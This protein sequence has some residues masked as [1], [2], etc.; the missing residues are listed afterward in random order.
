[1]KPRT[2]KGVKV[3]AKYL[4]DYTALAY[5]TKEKNI[6]S[7]SAYG[8]GNGNRVSQG[9]Y[10]MG[11]NDMCSLAASPNVRIKTKRGFVPINELKPE[12]E[13]AFEIPKTEKNFDNM[14]DE[15]YWEQG[16]KF[17]QEKRNAPKE[18]LSNNQEALT[19]FINGFISSA[20][21]MRKQEEWYDV[22]TFEDALFLHLAATK[23]RGIIAPIDD[24]GYKVIIPNKSCKQEEIWS[25]IDFIDNIWTGKMPLYALE[26]EGKTQTLFVNGYTIQIG[27][28]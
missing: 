1:M 11:A 18:M 20:K 12:E 26:Y 22:N 25:K 10:R 24:V 16:K 6:V 19:T 23:A 7:L 15:I 28:E 21:K 13:I 3:L 27:E 9:I 8:F 17:A 2:K 5:S 14:T 4:I